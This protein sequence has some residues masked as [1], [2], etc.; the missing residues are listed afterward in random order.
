MITQILSCKLHDN[1]LP[2]LYFIQGAY[3]YLCILMSSSVGFY[4]F[5]VCDVGS[6]RTLDILFDKMTT[7]WC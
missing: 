4:T 3:R 6:S 7:G 5:L 1:Y 2:I